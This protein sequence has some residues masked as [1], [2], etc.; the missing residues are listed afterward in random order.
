YGDQGQLDELKLH[1]SSF[2]EKAHQ[3]HQ[4][5][6]YVEV[7]LLQSKVAM[8]ELDVKE[9][10]RFLDLARNLADEKG[11]ERTLNRIADERDALIRALT[12]W[13]QLGEDRPPMT[14]RTEKVRI[15]EQIEKMI[16]E[17]SWRRMLF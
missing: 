5:G 8:V 10:Y 16:R 2:A 15:H 14:E 6:L 17:G 1:L 11:L 13:E 9:A 3:R 4:I 12:V 7:L